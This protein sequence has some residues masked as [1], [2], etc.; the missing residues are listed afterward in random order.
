M[1]SKHKRS[2]RRS[3]RGLIRILGSAAVLAAVVRELRKPAAERTWHGR[4]GGVLPYD[5]RPPT[6]ARMRDA[7][8]NPESRELFTPRVFGIGWSVNLPELFRRVG[9]SGWRSAGGKDGDGAP[10]E[11]GL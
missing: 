10:R 6:L 7:W 1:G 3:G 9:G 5:F 2:G 8:W 4:I 11:G